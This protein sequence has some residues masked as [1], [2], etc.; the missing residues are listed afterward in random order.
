MTRYYDV[1]S[2]WP[3]GF[4]FFSGISSFFISLCRIC[5]CAK[6]CNLVFIVCSL[7]VGIDCVTDKLKATFSRMKDTLFCPQIYSPER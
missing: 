7:I 4:Y 1:F 5:L 2:F 6:V 3:T